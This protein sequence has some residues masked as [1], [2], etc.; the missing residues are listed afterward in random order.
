MVP[1]PIFIKSAGE[2]AN[3]G[4]VAG[5]GLWR[6]SMHNLHP[7]PPFSGHFVLRLHA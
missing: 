7:L 4:W 1:Q 5:A 3:S 6:R 2:P